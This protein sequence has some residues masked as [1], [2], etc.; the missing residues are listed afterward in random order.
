MNVNDFQF[1]VTYLITI[2]IDADLDAD[3][4]N[5][6]QLL[7]NFPIHHKKIYIFIFTK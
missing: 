7:D 5:R 3:D 1:V 6:F 4:V 2:L